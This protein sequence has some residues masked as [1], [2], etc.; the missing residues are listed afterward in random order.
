[1]KQKRLDL[2]ISKLNKNK[3]HKKN[4]RLSYS[5]KLATNSQLDLTLKLVRR[6]ENVYNLEK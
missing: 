5:R 1:M 2:K 4:P 3:T 6:G